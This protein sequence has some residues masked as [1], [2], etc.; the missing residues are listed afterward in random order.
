MWVHYPEQ[1]NECL[2]QVY[3]PLYLPFLLLTP[4]PFYLFSTAGVLRGIEA[5][6]VSHTVKFPRG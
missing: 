6:S 2:L 1:R 5:L 3:H 4:D